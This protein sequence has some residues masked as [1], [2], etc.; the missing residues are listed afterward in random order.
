[1]PIK[2]NSSSELFETYKEIM[3]MSSEDDILGM[4]GDDGNRLY[5]IDNKGE[6]NLFCE[7]NGDAVGWG[8]YSLSENIATL[9]KNEKTTIKR[10]CAKKKN[11]K[12]HVAAIGTH[13]NKD[14]LFITSTSDPTK[15]EW[16]KIEFDDPNVQMSCIK[17]IFT[18]SYQNKFST[19]ADI[20]Q[21]NGHISRYFIDCNNENTNGRKWN[22]HPLPADFD[23]TINSCMGRKKNE[24]IPG[25]YTFGNLGT[26]QQIIY[27]PLY[28]VFDPDLP[29]TSVRIHIPSKIDLMTTQKTVDDYTNLFMCGEGKL[30][31]SKYDN[32]KDGSEAIKI[33]E[34]EEFFD[35]KTL[36]AYRIEAK[37]MVILWGHNKKGNVF[38]SYCAEEYIDDP[39]HWSKIFIHLEDV[40]YFCAYQNELTGVGSLIA[41]KDDGFVTLGTQSPKSSC[42]KYQKVSL[43]STKETKKFNS[44]ATKITVSD[45]NG[46]LLSNKDIWLESTDYSSVYINNKYYSLNKKP[47]KV[48]TD[49]NGIIK[50][51]HPTSSLSSFEFYI[52]E[53]ENDDTSKKTKIT[54]WNHVTDRLL[55]LNTIDRLK[56]AQIV[57]NDGS[58]EFLVGK[59]LSDDDLKSMATAMQMMTE[60][61]KTILT[62]EIAKTRNKDL[63]T[64]IMITVNNNKLKCYTDK[65]AYI[66]ASNFGMIKG[67]TVS[68]DGFLQY[69]Q[70]AASNNIITDFISDVVNVVKHAVEDAWQIFIHFIDNAYHFIVKLAGA[71]Y[72]FIINGID[73]LVSGIEIIWQAIKVT[74]EKIIDFV[75]F[76]FDW[77]DIKRTADVI[78]HLFNYQLDYF[79]S[80]VDKLEYDVDEIASKI[81][82]IVNDWASIDKLEGY[83]NKSI[84]ELKN[85]NPQLN[86]N[87]VQSSYLIDYFADNVARSSISTSQISS[88]KLSYD[89]SALEKFIEDEKIILE[90]IYTSLKMELPEDLSKMDF[91]TVTKKILALIL[92]AMVYTIENGIDQILDIVKEYI[93]LLKQYINT[94]IYIPVLSNILEENTEISSIS[95]LDIIAHVAAVPVNMIY[96]IFDNK[97]EQM[98]T[99]DEYK[100]IKALVKSANSDSESLDDIPT[101]IRHIVCVIGHLAG[102]SIRTIEIIVY[103]FSETADEV[104]AKKLGYLSAGLSFVSASL[105]FVGDIAFKPY[106][107]TGI[108]LF[109]KLPYV[110]KY[111][112]LASMI[113]CKIEE[114]TICEKYFSIWYSIGCFVDATIDLGGGITATSMDENNKHIAIGIIELVSKACGNFGS[115]LDQMIKYDKDP[116]TKSNMIIVREIL[117]GAATILDFTTGGMILAQKLPEST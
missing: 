111:F 25:T 47:I 1:M 38:Y 89:E 83:D 10:F 103:P 115:A 112:P 9:N 104:K 97:Q 56:N 23:N 79:E 109:E 20:E 95:V 108:P 32:Q 18:C 101:N 72:E 26:T 19:I 62:P 90:K 16:E 8:K 28:N 6:L 7:K 4:C 59:D 63:I 17:N 30:Y 96:K 71:T 27:T 80:M 46:K 12:F 117:V 76:I 44:Y 99:D 45:E 67:I 107:E 35:V 36:H 75:K 33:A 37:N 70:T 84:N 93:G 87:T 110:A 34:S 94:P 55:E 64:G 40:I 68:S 65:E 74:M 11:N 106:S 98:F 86:S 52:Y 42:W 22:P 69:N 14:D 88:N 81:R 102:A 50:I 41:C 78:K 29:P 24:V 51:V 21:P 60:A 92:D 48:T 2:F 66:K 31:I 3:F 58:K 114:N 73:A 91:L 15:P 43:P 39:S 85:S 105:D 100:E 57:H 113:V 13:N 116:E 49:I 61:K 82:K 53:N 77:Y 54:P 5:S